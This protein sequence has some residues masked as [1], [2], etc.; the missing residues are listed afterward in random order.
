MGSV[1]DL[2]IVKPP[3]SGAPG[4][5]HFIFSDRYSV[6]DWGEMP[7]TLRRKGSALCLIGA[8]FFEKLDEKG[9]KTHYRGVVEKGKVKRIEEL[10][11]PSDTME[12]TLFPVVKPPYNNGKY[13]YSWYS[14]AKSN[15]LIPLEIIYRNI[16]PEGSSVFRRLSSGELQPSDL[17]LKEPPSPGMILPEPFIEVSTK[18]ESTD[19]YVSWSEG[20]RIAGLSEEEVMYLRATV[21]SINEIITRETKRVGLTNEDGKVEFAYDPFRKLTVVDVVGTPDECRFTFNGVRV[22]KEIARHYYANSEWK[23]EIDE[24]KFKAKAEGI[25]EWKKFCGKKPEFL[26]P[27][28]KKLIEEMYTAC[29]NDVTGRQFFDTPPLREVVKSYR[30]FIEG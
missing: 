13:D 10:E 5:G 15:Y 3:S 4:V 23:K 17:G 12:V 18:L 27:S 29:A 7:D 11:G 1:K 25:R 14:P 20:R 9:I 2:E 21:Q 6:F 8:Y 30:E 26:P 16:L 28:L 19:R 24:A 22:S